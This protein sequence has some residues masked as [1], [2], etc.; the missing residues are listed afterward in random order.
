MAGTLFGLP[1]QQNVDINGRPLVGAQLFIYNAGTLTP[2]SVF[3]DS[4][5]TIPAT[6]PLVADAAGRN[7]SFWL[8]DGTYRARLTDANLIL[9]YDIDNI[10]A[11]GPSTS[12]GGGGGGGG[13][14]NGFVT[15]D[16][17]FVLANIT[18]TG[19][20][21]C[22]GRTI[23]SASS[24]ASE[25]A[26]NDTNS[27]Y[28]YLWNNFPNATCPVTGGRGANASA[29]FS[30]NKPIGAPDMR[31]LAA[32]GLDGMGNTPA[33]VLSDVGGSSTGAFTRTLAQS[34]LPTV[35]LSASGLTVNSHTHDQGTYA[36]VPHTHGN[37]SYVV[38]TSINNGTSVTRN[39]STPSDSPYQHAGGQ[40]LL[41]SS[42]FTS[43][44]LSLANGNI[45][46]TSGT[47][48]ALISGTSGGTA[49][50]VSGTVPLGGSATPVNIVQPV[51]Q[52]TWLISL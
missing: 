9:I 34:N 15:G 5:L 28:A 30:A 46:G 4:A 37:G 41:Q 27:L 25:R 29:D 1:L 12:S 42:S 43:D 40:T 7:P 47:T 26:N 45:S 3:T 32:I 10:L 6:F 14:T 51:I 49:P 24:G 36:T 8:P 33:G 38:G 11:I 2:A 16:M 20:V 50:G 22:N 21:R 39:L 18:R 23:G 19:F 13:T 17:I 48:V 52:G 44:T 35:S 31:N